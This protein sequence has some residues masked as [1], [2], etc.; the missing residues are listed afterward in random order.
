[1]SE[2][3]FIEFDELAQWFWKKTIDQANERIRIGQIKDAIGRPGITLVIGC[4][5][6][7]KIQENIFHLQNEF[8][9]LLDKYKVQNKVKWRQDFSALHITVYGLIKPEKYEKGK[10]WPLQ[11]D[12]YNY[13]METVNRA[14]SFQLCQ[15]GIGILGGGAIGIRTPSHQFLDHIREKF[16]KNESFSRLKRE[17]GEKVNKTII[18]RFLSDFDQD[19][20]SKLKRITDS[21]LNFEIGEIK[22]S[23]FELIHYKH[24]F[25]DRVFHQ[26]SVP[27]VK[28]Q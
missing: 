26:E 25:L 19:D 27:L 24:E 2:Y 23:H 7:T 22:V 5:L 1:M 17:G 21:L 10:F 18:G 11:Q 20:L 9:A 13:M 6:P 14:K 3:S 28:L 8:D 16:D 15:R 12:L 4:P